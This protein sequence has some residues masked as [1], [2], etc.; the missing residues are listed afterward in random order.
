MGFNVAEGFNKSR[1]LEEIFWKDRRWSVRGLGA[2]NN[3]VEGAP[4]LMI[5]SGAAVLSEEQFTPD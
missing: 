1:V 4:V 2:S 5:G 3:I